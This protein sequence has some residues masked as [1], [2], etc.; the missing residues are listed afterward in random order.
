MSFDATDVTHLTRDE[1]YERV[2]A[3]PMHT[4]AP[5][6]GISDVALK[7]TRTRMW[8]PTPGRG[9][10]AKR[11]AGVAVRRT[12]LP[13]LPASV[14]ASMLAA[15]FSRPPK[16][17]PDSEGEAPQDTGPVAD[18][19]RYEADPGHRIAVADV[20]P[21][22]H[23]L[24]AA[25]VHALRKAKTDG[26]HRLVPR[27]AR[28]LLLSV[29]LGTVDRAL[30]MMDAL[31]KALDERGFTVE[32][33]AAEQSDSSRASTVV[34]VGEERVGIALDERVDR[35]ERPRNPKDKSLYYGKQF[36]YVPTGR[37]AFRIPQAY[38]GVRASWAD[39]AKQ[40][41]EECLN[42]IVVGIVASA[43]AMKARRLEQ[44]ARQREY[45][46]VEERRQHAEWKRQEEAARIRALEESVVAWRRAAAIRQYV[47]AMRQAAEA[48]GAAD[49][50]SPLTEWLRWAES[51]AD[52]VDPTKRALEVPADPDPPRWLGYHVSSSNAPT[53]GSGPLW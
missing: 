27:S 12:P 49:E 37:L 34:Q 11:N 45:L 14:P 47:I 51:Y 1:L 7:K 23:P 36:D 10:W 2:W 30:C 52:R 43:E 15:S 26:Q 53:G 24:V 33:E 31:I 13:K 50:D 39:G 25:S 6:F 3:E 9:Y 19:M 21:R 17:A 18:Q 42:D 38:L 29:T 41:V 35:V 46:A 32:I 20:L 8:V 16:L 44:E 48:S 5:R 40:R 4:L 22:P 28:R